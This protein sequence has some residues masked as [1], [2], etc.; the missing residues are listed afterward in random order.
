MN[1]VFDPGSAAFVR[2]ARVARVAT[3]RPDGR[4]HVVPIC[5]VLDGDR[6][7]FMTEPGVKVDNLRADPR[8]GLAFD[9]YDEDWSRLRGVSVSGT[10]TVH[11]A[12]ERWE[13]GRELLY[14]KFPQFLPD[15]P[16]IEGRTL[17]V[18]VEPDWVS[19]GGV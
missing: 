18:E 3:T 6:V 7:L 17:I 10:A 15:V 11:E 9:E 4:L 19:R 12:G 5:P 2:D 16:I 14:A 13:R 8:V 1:A